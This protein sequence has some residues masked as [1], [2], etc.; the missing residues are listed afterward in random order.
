MTEAAARA[1]VARAAEAVGERAERLNVFGNLGAF[2]V[3][4]SP[5]LID[6]V[7]AQPE[8]AGA[9]A[10]RRPGD[11]LLIGPAR[12]AR[13]APSGGGRPPRRRSPR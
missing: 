6:E 1:V 13:A 11:D 4:G 2:L 3:C 7:L 10:N 5:S 9:I 12:R 8:V